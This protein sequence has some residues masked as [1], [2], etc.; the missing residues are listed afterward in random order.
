MMKFAQKLLTEIYK[1][2]LENYNRDYE[3][4]FDYDFSKEKS[5][6]APFFLIQN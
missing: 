5:L 4:Y 1:I 2:D 6:S 3:K